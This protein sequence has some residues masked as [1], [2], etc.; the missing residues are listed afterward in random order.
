MTTNPSQALQAG[1]T[2]TEAA[3]VCSHPA[4]RGRARGQ[5]ASLE[6]AVLTSPELLTPRV[7]ANT[8]DGAV[9][10]DQPPWMPAGSVLVFWGPSLSSSQLLLSCGENAEILLFLLIL[11]RAQKDTNFLSKHGLLKIQGL[12]FCSLT[13][14]FED[15]MCFQSTGMSLKRPGYVLLHG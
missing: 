8:W 13:S 10:E 6:L 5:Q 9:N 15:P 4:Q 14:D 3:G 12:K 7:S 1:R 2:A 11:L